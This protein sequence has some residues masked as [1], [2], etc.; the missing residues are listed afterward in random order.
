MPT[1][2]ELAGAP[3]LAQH[4]GEKIPV[5]IHGKSLV[6]NFSSD[7]SLNRELLFF[8]HLGAEALRM[9]DWKIVHGKNKPWELY[10]MKNDRTETTNLAA[11]EA[12]RMQKMIDRYTAYKAEI[13]L[14]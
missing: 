12:A 1:L 2:L 8:E 11:E 5:P 6:P 13:N 14:W 7:A 10:D 9:G 4:N 3:P